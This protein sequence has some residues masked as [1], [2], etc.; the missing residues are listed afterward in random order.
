MKKKTVYIPIEV[1][2]REFVSQILFTYKLVKAGYRVYIGT[3]GQIFNF[4]KQKK[5]KAG[6]FFYKAGVPKDYVDLV[7]NKTDLHAVLDQE[8]MPGIS[9]HREYNEWVN[10]FTKKGEKY[11][12]IYFAVNHIVYKSAKNKLKK[13]RG[14]VYLTG[15]PRIDL[16]KKKYHKIFKEDVDLIKKKYKNF[17]L[18]NSDFQYITENYRD[19]ALDFLKP[20]QLKDWNLGK[21]K[22]LTKRRVKLAKSLNAEFNDAV[23]NIKKIS[24]K[25]KNNIIVRPHPG[26]NKF[27]WKNRLKNEEKIKVVSPVDDVFPWILASKGV[28]HRG[29]TTSL[30]SLFINK[31]TFF[32]YLGKKYLDNY[33]LK[34]VSFEFSTRI[35]PE[36]IN[37][38]YI[39][40]VKKRNNFFDNYLGIQ[41][42][43][44]SCDAMI[45]IFE[46]HFV[47]KEDEHLSLIN[48]GQESNI[49]LKIKRLLLFFYN[50]FKPKKKDFNRFKKMSSGINSSEVR[51]YLKKL[52]N[53]NLKI[54]QLSKDIV[55]IEK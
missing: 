15:S 17:Y 13:I 41:N 44:D 6:I 45:E 47:A 38:N 11:V 23:K 32:L 2:V 8:L 30:Q 51:K 31:P 33:K 1:K 29:C 27:T 22:N 49:K 26:E 3:R 48:Y 34:K 55:M 53:I 25:L 9:A 20:D 35:I 37:M 14:K 4:L 18:F 46:K 43:K 21:I 24:K 40:K 12:D 42:Q 36:K 39:N 28:I 5:Q 19:E 52:S 54:K 50:F 16:W 10:C 7:K